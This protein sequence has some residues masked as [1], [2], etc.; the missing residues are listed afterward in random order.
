MLDS[1]KQLYELR[2][3]EWENAIKSN[4]ELELS[5]NSAD[6]MNVPEFNQLVDMGED[7]IPLVLDDLAHERRHWNVHLYEKLQSDTTLLRRSEYSSNQRIAIEYVV[8]WES[9]KGR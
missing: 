4:P 5:S 8:Q 1:V 6:W 9:A 2:E 3:T 7:I